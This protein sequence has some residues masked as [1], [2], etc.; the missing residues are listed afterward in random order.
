[1]L[2]DLDDNPVVVVINSPDEAF[3]LEAQALVSVEGWTRQSLGVW[4]SR[5]MPLFLSPVRACSRTP[6]VAKGHTG[7]LFLLIVIF[8]AALG[9][10]LMDM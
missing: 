5:T 1:M 2:A 6:L 10:G 4:S 9:K 7:A 8:G 3:M